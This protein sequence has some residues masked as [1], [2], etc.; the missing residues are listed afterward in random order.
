MRTFVGANT[1]VRK[2]GAANIINTILNEMTFH[3]ENSFY[4]PE[5]PG[6]RPTHRHWLPTIVSPAHFL[7]HL[8]KEKASCWT[9]DDGP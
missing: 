7:H 9:H 5:Y 6:D 2:Y 3:L 1:F 8:M 4:D